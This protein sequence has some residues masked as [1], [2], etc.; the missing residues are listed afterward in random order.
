[1]IGDQPVFNPGLSKREFFAAMAL[2]GI[3]ANNAVR[4]TNEGAAAIAVRLADALIEDLNK[5][6]VFKK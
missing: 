4:G 6:E 3:A 5:P 1:M 2:A